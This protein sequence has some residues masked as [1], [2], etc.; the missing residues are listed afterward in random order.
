MTFWELGCMGLLEAPDGFLEGLPTVMSTF[1]YFTLCPFSL[2]NLS[3]KRDYMSPTS[4]NKLLS[5][6]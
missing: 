3:Y 2:M 1:A 6:V 4:P 5:L